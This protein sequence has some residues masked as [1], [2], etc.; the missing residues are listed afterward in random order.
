ME[1]FIRKLARIEKLFF[2]IFFLIA[3]P[4]FPSILLESNGLVA[5]SLTH[6]K[7]GASS[8][9]IGIRFLPAF[10][11]S[12]NFSNS[13][14]L[15]AEASFNTYFT[16]NFPSSKEPILKGRIK[17]YRLSLKYSSSRFEVRIGLQKI[18]FGSASLIRPLMWFDRI[19]P[20]DPIQLTDGVYSL[21]IRTFIAKKTNLW[22]WVLYGNENPK[23]WEVF[24][25]ERK[26]PELGFRNQIPL[27]KGE[28]AFS[29][30]HRK[31]FFHKKD[32]SD[33]IFLNSPSNGDFKFSEERYALD[34]KWD[35]GVGVWFEAVFSNQ[36]SPNFIYPW[37]RSFTAGIDYTFPIGNGVHFLTEYFMNDLSKKL[38]SKEKS[39]P[40]QFLAL[41]LSYSASLLDTLSAIIYYDSKNRDFY[42]FARWQRNYD[43]WS[44]NLIAFSNP[45]E[46]RIYKTSEDNFFAGKGFLLMIVYNY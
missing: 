1:D 8:T 17:P 44:I 2:P 27:G 7:S 33:N 20:R 36:R 18:S 9:Q 40:S 19:D 4:L 16:A 34:G 13:R 43:R 14:S 32:N 23:G 37:Q 42:N 45:E 15:T 10:S 29:F 5:S 38:F 11:L 25:T 6:S 22:F 12:H 39:P 24:P 41:S 26:S 21:L 35:I 46:F 30:H 31:G 3:P 28:L